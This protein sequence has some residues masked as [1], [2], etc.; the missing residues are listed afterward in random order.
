[1]ETE[2]RRRGRRLMAGGVATLGG[3]F[4]R[5]KWSCNALRSFSALSNSA[6]RASSSFCLAVLL[7]LGSVREFG[8]QTC[9]GGLLVSNFLLLVLEQQ[10]GL[11]NGGRKF[12][13]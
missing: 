4:S 7:G 6:A 10:L 5:F 11:L 13:L 3:K 8:F 1:M 2:A 12:Y 9:K